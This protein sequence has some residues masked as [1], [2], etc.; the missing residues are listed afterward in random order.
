M[1]KIAEIY[2]DNEDADV[3]FVEVEIGAKSKSRPNCFLPVNTIFARVGDD[4]KK[5]VFELGGN[6]FE[7][8]K[9]NEKD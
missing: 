4:V 3:L 8:E 1:K 6:D 5:I 9:T 2:V 7:S